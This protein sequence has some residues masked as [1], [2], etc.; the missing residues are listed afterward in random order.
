MQEENFANNLSIPGIR[1]TDDLTKFKI[2]LS[3]RSR[4]QNQKNK[5]KNKLF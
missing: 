4:N 1:D 2:I 3:L 5:W